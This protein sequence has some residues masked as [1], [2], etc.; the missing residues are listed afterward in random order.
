MDELGYRIIAI[1]T[2]VVLAAIFIVSFIFYVKTPS[3]L[4]KDP[5]EEACASCQSASCLYKK[6]GGE[7]K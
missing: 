4:K 7:E 1:S 6:K 2:C 5:S 3:P